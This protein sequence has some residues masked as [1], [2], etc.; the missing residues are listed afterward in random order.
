MWDKGLHHSPSAN[1][2]YS[3]TSL[4][5]SDCAN[6][7]LAHICGSFPHAARGWAKK[8]DSQSIWKLR[9]IQLLKV[10]LPIFVIVDVKNNTELDVL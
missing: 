7:L 9:I 2:I 8:Y 1:Q 3:P 10:L 6:R 4:N 5:N